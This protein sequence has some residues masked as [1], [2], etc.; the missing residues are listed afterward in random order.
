MVLC[1]QTTALCCTAAL[2]AT[3]TCAC[4]CKQLLQ[5]KHR[6][7][8]KVAHPDTSGALRAQP[9]T[10]TSVLPEFGPPFGPV[11]PLLCPCLRRRRCLSSSA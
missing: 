7:L 8:A 10:Q 9:L 3:T 11:L 4:E 5:L 2:N 1:S 6:L